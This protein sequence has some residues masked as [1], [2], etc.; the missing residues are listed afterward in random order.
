MAACQG[1]P[2]LPFMNKWSKMRDVRGHVPK[3][4]IKKERKR[5]ESVGCLKRLPACH[6]ATALPVCL[7][8]INKR[9]NHG[10][11]TGARGG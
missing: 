10:S 8:D 6:H 4:R 9:V 11:S 3:G 2:S 7:I 1:P 5:K